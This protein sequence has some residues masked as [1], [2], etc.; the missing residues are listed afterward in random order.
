MS[1]ALALQVC[2]AS[3]GFVTRRASPALPSAA[4]QGASFPSR[5]I[6][7]RLRG[8]SKSGGS[9]FGDAWGRGGSGTM[10]S[11]SASAEPPAFTF[12]LLADIQYVDVDD[13]PNFTG[14]QWRRYRNALVVAGDAVKYFNSRPELDFVLHNGDIIDHQCAFDFEADAFKPKHEAMSALGEVMSVLSE[15]RCENWHFTVG[16]HELYNF[17]RDELRDGVAAPGATLPFRCADASGDFF[18][19]FKPCAGWRVLVLD[20]Y[21]V[22]IYRN[23]RERGLDAEALATLCANNANC[24]A[25]VAANPDILETERMSGTF[26][27]F[28]DLEGLN[29]RWVPF[30]GGVGE[31]QLRWVKEQ[32]EE[33]AAADERVVLFSH[34]L[35]HPESTAKR[36][37]RTLLWNFQDLLDV[38]EHPGVSDRVAAVI[39]GHQHDG[40]VYTSQHGTHYVVMESPI[41]AEKG[42]PGPYAV[43]E[44]RGESLTF[45]GFGKGKDS[46]LFPGGAEAEMR[47]TKGSPLTRELP[48]RPLG[49]KGGAG[50]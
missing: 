37:G 39:S 6:A 35:V 24:D 29:S 40:G 36:S 31:T 16:N 7:H 49:G 45:V 23:G 28:K 27:Y 43:V 48:L 47:E 10:A 19:A 26:P 46:N 41:V 32:L 17:T 34:L 15:A 44:A 42:Y 21:D 33:A 1:R 4:R 18:Y 9:A 5:P 11:A 13:K 3:T 12:G 30:N 38:L 20:A 50:A 14:T 8:A 2:G 22:S 25:Y